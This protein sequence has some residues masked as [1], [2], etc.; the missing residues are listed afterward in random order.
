[1]RYAQPLHEWKSKA[2]NEP[3]IFESK[4]GG[5]PY[6]PADENLPV[7]EEGNPMKLLAQINCKDLKELKDYPTE[8][9]IQFYLTT[10][11]MWEEAVVKYY[12]Q[13]DYNIKSEVVSERIKEIYKEGNTCFPVEGEYGLEF[14]EDEESMSRDDDRLMAL[15]CQYYTEL[16]GEW[17]S[18]PEDAGDEVYELF[19]SYCDNSYAG[20]HKIGGYQ[21]STQPADYFQYEKDALPIDVMADDGEVLLFQMDSELKRTI[22]WGDLGVAQFFIKRSDLKAKKFENAYFT[23][24]CS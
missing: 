20:G 9:M 2:Q 4:I 10:N 17:I 19:E 18:M 6:L 22:M 8:G 11:P 7:D 16:S 12:S 3:L 14:N 15:F 23:W 1:M 5:I 24:D 21:S 13:V